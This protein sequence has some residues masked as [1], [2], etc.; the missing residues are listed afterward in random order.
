MNKSTNVPVFDSNGNIN[1]INPI[2]VSSVSPIV[3]TNNGLEILYPIATPILRPI[4]Q[5]INSIE[6][7]YLINNKTPMSRIV[8]NSIESSL[9][10][11]SNS[12]KISLDKLCDSKSERKCEDNQINKKFL[13]MPVIKYK[14]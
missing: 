10:Y 5:T 14:I 9:F 7:P 6:I 2:S 4:L 11:P 12:N 1:I 3:R 13:F 8:Q